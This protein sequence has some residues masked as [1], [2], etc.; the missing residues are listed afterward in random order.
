MTRRATNI[1]LGSLPFFAAGLVLPV[2]TMGWQDDAFHVPGSWV[3][4]GAGVYTCVHLYLMEWQGVFWG[5][6]YL[7]LVA[8]VACSPVM[9][10]RRVADAWRY[11][12]RDR[13][14]LLVKI[15]LAILAYLSPLAWG[16]ASL[17]GSQD[18]VTPFLFAGYWSWGIGLLLLVAAM[19]CKQVDAEADALGRQRQGDPWSDRFTALRRG[20]DRAAPGLNLRRRLPARRR[21][22]S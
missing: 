18:V 2:G 20:I 6:L 4:F 16:V 13:V 8:W 17:S 15:L 21:R 5:M 12:W 22:S 9:I 11:R 10:L 1:W 14:R 3:I 19:I 7:Y